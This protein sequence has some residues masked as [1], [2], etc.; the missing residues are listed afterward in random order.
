MSVIHSITE[1]GQTFAH[2]MRMFRQVVKINF[3]TSMLI[4][5]L[6]FLYLMSQVKIATYYAVAYHTIAYVF[7]RLGI[8]NVTVYT[9]HWRIFAYEH[10]SGESFQ[11]PVGTVLSRTEKHFLLAKDL[12]IESLLI[13][14]GIFLALFML[15]LILF[16]TKGILGKL[17][18]QISGRKLT[19]AFMLKWKLILSRKASSIRVGKVPLLKNAETQHILITGGTGSGKTNCMLHLLSQLRQRGDKVLIIDT[20][21]DFL[22]SF[23]TSKTDYV[24]NPL[25]QSSQKW[26]PWVECENESDYRS[27]AES[28]IPTSNYDNDNYWRQASKTL[29]YTILMQ[30]EDKKL[31]SELTQW[32][33]H[34]SLQN[35]CKF[36]EGTRG[37]THMDPNSDKTASSIRSV[38]STFVECLELIENT[39]DPFSV[40]KWV[41]DESNNGWLF[42]QTNAKDRAALNP[43]ISVWASIAIRSLLGLNPNL[44]RRIW[45]F[46]DE[47]ASLNPIKDL[48]TLLTEGRKYGACGIVSL[49]STSQFEDLYG[50]E[51]AEVMLGN[52][53]T[54]LVF[55][56]Q[57]PTVADKI[58]KV[59]GTKE[60]RSV[61]EGISYGAHETRDGVNLS[62]YE[63][64]LPIISPTDIMNLE[65]NNLYIG[66]PENYP[67]AKIK[68]KI[69]NKERLR[70]S[71]TNND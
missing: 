15:F 8:Q 22:E 3:T 26:H 40:K 13:A 71:N 50:R 29:F 53:R 19:S 36:V 25:S 32:L 9:S 10:Y 66:L 42:L 11:S 70:V 1:G 2:R 64:A 7:L 35:L 18:K 47:L 41:Q 14:L 68:L 69:F 4:A 52:C 27:L 51:K 67:I 59:F 57:N 17:Q 39:S 65:R 20:N 16:Y 33:L 23:Y 55:A 38:M 34:E 28:F 49:Q 6:F 5:V 12:A 37:A 61:N 56:E 60:I 43:L 31:T 58:S 30:L 48:L 54:K 62:T 21:G 44:N 63:K 45:F 46:L 24:L